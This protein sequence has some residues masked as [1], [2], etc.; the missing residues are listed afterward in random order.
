MEAGELGPK[1]LFF[2]VRLFFETHLSSTMNEDPLK[3]RGVVACE[4][5]SRPFCFVLHVILVPM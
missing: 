1:D 5:F 3:Q 4:N 2:F